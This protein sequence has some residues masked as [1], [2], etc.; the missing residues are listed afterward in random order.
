M[1]NPEHFAHLDQTI[2]EMAVGL[3]ADGVHPDDVSGPMMRQS[4]A[5]LIAAD[6]P[7][8]TAKHLRDLA[9]II[10]TGGS[11]ASN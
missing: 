8:S 7:T 4:I 11:I 2:E 5:I 1:A 10:E 9:R 6:G 3:I